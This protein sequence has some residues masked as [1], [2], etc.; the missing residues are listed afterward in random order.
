MS[1]STSFSNPPAKLLVSRRQLAIALL[2]GDILGLG[3]SLSLALWFRFGQ[4]SELHPLLYGVGLLVLTGLYLVDAYRPELQ[5]QGVWV[6]LRI[7]ISNSTIALLSAAFIY[8]SGLWAENSLLGRG[9]LL[10]SLGLFTSWAIL[11]R[12]GAIAWVQAQHD[13]WLVLGSGEQTQRFIQDFSASNSSGRL[14]LTENSELTTFHPLT[15]VEK[16]NDRL[17]HHSHFGSGIIVSD[18]DEL[19]ESQLSHLMYLRLQGT[20]IYGLLDFYETFFYKLPSKLLSDSWFVSSSGYR[21]IGDRVSL[22]IKR[23]IDVVSA[24]MLLIAFSPVIIITAIAIRL[25]SPG[26]VLYSQLRSGLN[27][28]PFKVYKFRSMYQ[29]AETRG[30]QW[31][32]EHDPRIT[33]VGRWLRLMRIDELPQIWNVLR[34]EMSLIGPRPERPEF[35]MQLAAAIPYYDVRYWVKPG[36]TGWAQVMYPYGASVEDAYEKL[37]YDLYYIKHYSLW[38]EWAIAFKTIRVVLLGKGR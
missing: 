27:R 29:D 5:I 20:S 30:A 24:I 2:A 4:L 19:T 22:K 32:Q 36:I 16:S 23:M 8:L 17:T 31:A 35:D 14:V 21:L 12:W 11:L 25:D 10:P 3:I 33:R 7:V 37:A 38:L 15:W 26:A 18:K 34:G 13:R 1:T 6:S 9:V 28:K